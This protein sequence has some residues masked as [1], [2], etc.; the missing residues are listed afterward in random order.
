[1]RLGLVSQS[2][3]KTARPGVP[4]MNSLESIMMFCERPAVQG[5][6]HQQQRRLGDAFPV[7]PSL[8][9]WEEGVDGLQTWGLG[10]DL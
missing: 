3:W 6:L 2:L 5:F 8:G 7:V 4:C 9:I 10:L 1:M